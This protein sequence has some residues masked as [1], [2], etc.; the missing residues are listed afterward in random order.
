MKRSLL[1]V[2]WIGVVVTAVFLR[3]DD[4]GARPMHADEATGARITAERLKGGGEFNP[5]HYHGPVLADLAGMVSVARGEET[6]SELTELSLRLVTATA[7]LLLVLLP[8][9]VRKRYGDGVVLAAAAFIATSPLLIYYSRMFIHETLLVLFG[10]AFL[11]LAIRKPK[12]G[13]PGIML[14]L[15]YATK[16]T[17]VISV[18]AWCAAASVLLI[19][20]R[21]QL[22]K[23]W[24]RAVWNEWKMPVIVSGCLAALVSMS[25][26]TDAFRHPQGAIDAIKTFFVYKTGEGHDKSVSYYFSLLVLPEKSAGR[27]WFSVPMISLAAYAYIGSFFGG[28]DLKVKLAIRFLFYAFIA[29]LVIYSAI[30]YKTP[31]LMCLPW[32]HVCLL[33]G[34]SVHLVMRQKRWVQCAVVIVLCIGLMTSYQQARYATGRLSSDQR[35]PLAYVPT[36]KS[37]ERLEV[38]LERLQKVDPNNEVNDVAVVGTGYWPLPWYLRG[39]ERVGYWVAADSNEGFPPEMPIV[40]CMPEEFQRVQPLLRDTHYQVPFGYGLRPDVNVEVFVRLDLWDAWSKS[41]GS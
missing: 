40:I 32:A 13:F 15:M 21:D 38:W 31:W 39:F 9:L 16:E 1:I 35:N 25:I 36:R 29:H 28:M 20:N 5:S 37:V 33:A 30:A 8:L 41:E 14:G 4:L 10:V 34:F 12:M 19:E 27:W 2:G 18:M 24:I 11:V 3:F 7:G 26:Y 22:N 23:D 6:W 17:F